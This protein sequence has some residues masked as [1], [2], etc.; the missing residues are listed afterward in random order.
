V[1]SIRYAIERK[2]TEEQMEQYADELR[3]KN[4]QLQD[5]LNMAKEIQQ[6][7][8]PSRYPVFLSSAQ[9][10]G[11]ALRFHHIY[12]PSATVG[13]DFFTVLPISRSKAGVFICD[14]MGHGMRAALV[15]ALVRG[16]TEELRPVAHDPGAFLTALNRGLMAILRHS[17]ELVFASAAYLVAD[18]ESGVLYSSNAGHPR[19]MLLRRSEGKAEYLQ[20]EGPASGPA[21]GINDAHQY[22]STPHAIRNQD[23]L[24]LYTD[25]LYEAESPSGEQFG[26]VRLRDTVGSVA[27]MASARILDQMI[28]AVE[29]FTG[30]RRIEDDICIL[31]MEVASLG[32]DAT[33]SDD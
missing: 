15:T 21:L 20:A 16:L 19:P 4:R 26:E 32:R 18:V 13:G 29:S 22:G 11:S 3:E 5:D 1:R 30:G 14:V 12:R 31:G 9:Q 8:L 6:A 2:K 33:R 23:L 7:L 25:G 27:C 24:V 17:N 10:S 28:S